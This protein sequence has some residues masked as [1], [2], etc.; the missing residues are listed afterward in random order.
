MGTAFR[1]SCELTP[2][3]RAKRRI[4]LFSLTKLHV[5][6]LF[7]KANF[8]HILLFL[9]IFYFFLIFSKKLLIQHFFLAPFLYSSMISIC[10][11]LQNLCARFWAHASKPL[12]FSHLRKT[13]T[14][15][16][17][18]FS[19]FPTEILKSPTLFFAAIFVRKVSSSLFFLF[20]SFLT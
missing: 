12:S 19:E 1:C 3:A 9:T 20:Y 6:I 10:V 8:T 18:N 4:S 13:A 17:F 5:N 16:S 7:S 14:R 11:Q 15:I 2:G